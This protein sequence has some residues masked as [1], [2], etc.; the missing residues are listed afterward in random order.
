[1][2]QPHE[3]WYDGHEPLHLALSFKDS[4]EK[5]FELKRKREMVAIL[6]YSVIGLFY[7][8]LLGSLKEIDII[9]KLISEKFSLKKR[10][11]ED[12]M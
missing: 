5:V 11:E 3:C 9:S 10:G 4:S 2:L 7:M 12:F 8:E 6:S 1:M